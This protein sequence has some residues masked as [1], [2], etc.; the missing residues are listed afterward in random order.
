MRYPDEINDDLGLSPEFTD[1]AN[2]ED[3]FKPVAECGFCDEPTEVYYPCYSCKR[4]VCP[5]CLC[6]DATK[7]FHYC[8]ECEGACVLI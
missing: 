8:P 1:R 4:P 5:C 2:Y 3:D 6:W 7:S